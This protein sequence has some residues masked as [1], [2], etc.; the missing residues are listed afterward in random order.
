[1]SFEVKMGEEN[2]ETEIA[3]HPCVSSLSLLPPDP[4]EPV[5]LLKVDL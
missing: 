4:E 5:L 2:I 1:M 3:P